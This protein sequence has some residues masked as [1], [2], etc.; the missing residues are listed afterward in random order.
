MAHFRRRMYV[1][2]L[3]VRGPKQHSIPVVRPHKFKAMTTSVI[4]MMAGS[5]TG[6]VIQLEMERISVIGRL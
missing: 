4:K 6:G 3:R 2:A 5:N 1:D